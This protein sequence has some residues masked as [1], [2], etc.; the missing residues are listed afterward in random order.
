MRG[1]G[2]HRNLNRR[3]LFWRRGD[4]VGLCGVAVA[5]NKQHARLVNKQR[6]IHIYII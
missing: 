2:I 1:V 3:R 6:N 4:G 5:A